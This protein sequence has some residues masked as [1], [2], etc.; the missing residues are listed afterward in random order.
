MVFRSNSTKERKNKVYVFGFLLCYTTNLIFH[1]DLPTFFKMGQKSDREIRA[2]RGGDSCFGTLHQFWV[3]L[4]Y[5][6]EHKTD[7][8]VAARNEMRVCHRG[9]REDTDGMSFFRFILFVFNF[10]MKFHK[11]KKFVKYFGVE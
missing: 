8:C 7:E 6:A 2:T 5:L 9:E 3:R 11:D 1:G 10:R 4:K